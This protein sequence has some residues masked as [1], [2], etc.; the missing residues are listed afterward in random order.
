MDLK[1]ICTM[2]MVNAVGNVITDQA[3]DQTDDAPR[4]RFHT[5]TGDIPTTSL[6]E[7]I[8]PATNTSDLWQSTASN[9]TTGAT[10]TFTT[11]SSQTA[12]STG[13]AAYFSIIQDTAGGTP[14]L[15]GT[16]GTSGS[17]INFNTVEWD[18]GDNIS[19]TSLS[20]TMPK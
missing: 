12:D 16:V 8:V 6:A 1:D 9:N 15:T 19:I 2:A 14:V 10:G 11:I 13:T 3:F 17:D 5:A 20:F 4:I 18:S 7:L